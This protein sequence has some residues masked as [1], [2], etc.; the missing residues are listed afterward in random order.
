[1]VNDINT[2]LEKS[3]VEDVN[4]ALAEDIGSGDLTAELVPASQQARATLISREDAV[5]CG[6]DWFERVF[7]ELSA[8]TQINWNLAEG[9]VV[10]PGATLCSIEGPARAILSGERTAM[11]FLQT[12]SGTATTA[13]KFVDAVS[14]TDTVIL[15]TRKTLPGLRLAQ[16][17]AVRTGG[18]QNH[19]TGLYDGILIK[20]NHIVACGG[21]NN[22]VKEAL[23]Q[24]NTVL[25]E[26]EV[27][28]LDEAR[29][30]I[31]AGAQRLLLDNFSLNEMRA[32]V[33]LRNELKQQV[34]LEASGNVTLSTVHDIASTGVDF[35]SIGLLT[36]DVHAIDLSMRFEM[37]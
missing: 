14:D 17:Y 27:E 3:L 30:A 10:S 24:N 29:A 13:R 21:I 32:A 25:I 5:I 31:N 23:Q 20:E 11:N 35:I 34:G 8:A 26:V 22:A 33:L 15:D 36:K 18:A 19:R 12:L 2:E 6:I 16:K 28:S 9:D 7:A 1:V 4:T 37:L